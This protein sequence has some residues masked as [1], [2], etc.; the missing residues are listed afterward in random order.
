MVEAV[1]V[2]VEVRERTGKGAARAQR[3][4]GRIPAVIYG[5]KQNPI[6]IS[7]DDRE[8][9]KLFHGPRFFTQIFELNL[10]GEKHQVLARD[11]QLHPVTDGPLHVDFM[12][13]NQETRIVLLIPATFINDELSPGLKRGGVLNIVRR[14]VELLCSPLNIPGELVFDL[15]G[16]D[17]GDAIHIGATELPEDVATTTDRDFTVATIAAPTLMPSDEEEAESEE[18]EEGEEGMDGEEGVDGEVVSE[19]TAVPDSSDD[20][21]NSND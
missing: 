11:L 4:A 2:S 10:D 13:F 15:E 12:R 17:I 3:R 9:A 16:L 19:D 20:G 6:T 7:V 21:A 1:T 5:D 18:G 14:E 8:L